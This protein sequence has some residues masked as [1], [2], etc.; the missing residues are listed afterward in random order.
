MLAEYS[1]DGTT[2][3]S[4]DADAGITIFSTETGSA[5]CTVPQ[6]K[7]SALSWSPTGQYLLAWNRF[8]QGGEAH[9]H[10]HRFFLRLCVLSPP[11]AGKDSPV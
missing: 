3:A 1:P 2:I 9:R 8:T 6:L 7:V 10:F 11:C 5:V 4:V